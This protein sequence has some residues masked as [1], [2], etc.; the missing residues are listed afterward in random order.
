MK[1]KYANRMSG[2]YKQ[3]KIESEYF[4][5]YLCYTKLKDID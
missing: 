2:I 3:D 4:N 1:R 5:G